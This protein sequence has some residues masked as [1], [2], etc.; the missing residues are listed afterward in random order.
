MA[1]IVEL[2]VLL[3]MATNQLGADRR[4]NFACLMAA[5]RPLLV[6]EFPF[7]ARNANPAQS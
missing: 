2:L 5:A 7:F 6:L 3:L 4:M 1:S